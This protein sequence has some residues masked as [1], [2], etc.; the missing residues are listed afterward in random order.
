VDEETITQLN[1]QYL[2]HEGVTDVITF[3]LEALPEEPEL[4]PETD[5]AEEDGEVYICLPRALEQAIHYGVSVNEEVARLAL[6][7][8]L[9]LAGWDDRSDEDREN[10]AAREDE[11]LKRAKRPDC[12]LPWH[13]QAPS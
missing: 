12:S 2:G 10:M 1:E 4:E 7:G 3:D 9:H 8:L 6:H 11:G 13:V 5:S